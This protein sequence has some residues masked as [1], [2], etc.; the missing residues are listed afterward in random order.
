MD[1]GEA[2]TALSFIA[3]PV[4]IWALWKGVENMEGQH[5]VMLAV[6]LAAGYVLGRMWTT[7]AQLV[8]LP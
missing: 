6:V 4:T 1:A 2:L 8:G 5:W 7:P 3:A